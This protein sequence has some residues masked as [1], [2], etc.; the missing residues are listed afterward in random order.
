[1]GELELDVAACELAAGK[2]GR[3]G[4]PHWHTSECA[5]EDGPA[6]VY[7]GSYA[8]SDLWSDARNDR[9]CE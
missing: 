5:S 1:M 9:R 8:G 7:M 3:D 2:P 4:L 6:G